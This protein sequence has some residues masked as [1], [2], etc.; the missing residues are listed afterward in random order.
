M[1]I[2]LE[3]GMILKH[4]RTLEVTHRVIDLY[5]ENNQKMAFILRIELDCDITR[6]LPVVLYDTLDWEIVESRPTLEII[7]VGHGL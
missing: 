3:R 1:K 5:E 4:R 2:E 7:D 6:E